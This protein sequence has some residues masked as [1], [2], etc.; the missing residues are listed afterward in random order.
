MQRNIIFFNIYF[1]SGLIS[2]FQCADKPK[3][4]EGKIKFSQELKPVEVASGEPCRFECKIDGDL[5]DLNVSWF[6]DGEELLPNEHY[7]FVKDADGTIALLI[8]SFASKDVGTYSVKIFNNDDE[9]SSSAKAS[10]KSDSI[11]NKPKIVEELQDTTAEEGTL[12]CLKCQISPDAGPVD[13]KWFQDNKQLSEND[14]IKFLNFPDGT[15]ML[16]IKNIES[17]NAGNY[18]VV[19]SNK[20]GDASSEA[21]VTVKRKE[22]QKPKMIKG[23]EPV[24]LIAGKPGYL[25][26]QVDSN[27]GDIKFLLNSQHVMPDDRIHVKQLP[28]GIVRLN[29]DEV[30]LN[31]AGNYTAVFKNAGGSTESSALVTVKCKFTKMKI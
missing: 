16:Q 10:L 19:I 11:K 14:S 1:V 4:K 15:V 28:D 17:S 8:D 23:L 20:A 22:S 29:F 7:G 2:K 24:T 18:K 21:K 5:K 9:A 13:C 27:D 26:F 6:K 31:D 3:T 30:T 12:L 25:E